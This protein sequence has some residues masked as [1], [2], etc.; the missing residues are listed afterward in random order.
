F[1]PLRDEPGRWSFTATAL[2]TGTVLT[3]ERR[4][5]EQLAEQLEPLRA[6]LDQLRA[7]ARER[8]DE[9]HD[10]Y[11]QAAIE[12]SAGHRGEAPLPGTFVDYELH[13]R[14]YELSVAQT[15]LRVHTRV[16]DL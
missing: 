15:I 1:E 12:L 2:T 13:P 3:L 6:H 10:R 16:A 8:H 11:G 14:E 4:V 5:L 9:P 7:R